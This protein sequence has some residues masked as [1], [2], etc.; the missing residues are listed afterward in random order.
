MTIAN[1]YIRTV[2]TRLCVCVEAAL[3]VQCGH[4]H[5]SAR[6]EVPP[7]GGRSGLRMQSGMSV[8]TM[9]VMCHQCVEILLFPVTK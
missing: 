3:H 5:P 7:P 2:R 9:N 4:I 8:C 6:V 1:R